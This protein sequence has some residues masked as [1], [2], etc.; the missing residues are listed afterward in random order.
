[1]Q[2]IHDAILIYVTREDRGGG[3]RIIFGRSVENWG[4]DKRGGHILHGGFVCS[5]TFNDNP[6]INRCSER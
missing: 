3:G 6:G 4:R 2:N 1:M 5:V